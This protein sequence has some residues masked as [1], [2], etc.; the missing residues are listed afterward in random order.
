MSN[1]SPR[2]VRKLIDKFFSIQ[3]CRDN[4]VVPLH[5]ENSLP[6]IR[7]TIKIAIANFS[8]L[9]T[10]ASPIKERL[11]Q[12]GY[13]CE[14]VERSQEEI[15]KILDL[16]SEE[17]FLTGDK[18]SQFDEDAVLEAIKETS[19][20]NSDTFDFEFDDE[21]EL[22]EDMT[23][24]LAVE[25]CESKIQNAA[26]TILINARQRNVSDIH[27]EP[28]ENSYLVRVRKDGVMH[29]FMSLPRKAGIQLVACLKNMAYMDIAERRVSQDGKI[30]RKFE[31]NKIEFR[32]STVPNT[33]G[34][35]MVLRILNSDASTLNLDF[36]I[37]IESVRENFRKI[38]S[39]NNGII[40]VSGP[41]G[42]GKSTTLAATLIELNNGDTNIVTAEDPVEYKLGGGISQSQVNRAKGQT[43]AMLLR[44]FL[45]QDPDVILIGETRDPETAESAMD[46]AETGHLVFTTLHANSS[47]SSLTRLIDM[48]V[49]KYKLNA[50]VRGVLAQRL[51][52]K[53]C[54]GCGT[55]RGVSE[56]ESVRYGIDEGTPV[57][58]ANALSAE[59]K[60]K[61]KRESSLCP[62]CFGI[63][64]QGRIGVYELLEVNRDIQIAIAE[65]KS[66]E[67]IEN[68]AVNKNNMLT[69]RKY[70]LELIKEGL[71]TFSELERVI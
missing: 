21:G 22:E 60:S 3:W 57:M 31:G 19:D 17:R 33:N 44:T 49:P 67:E 39:S 40:I 35:K 45:R 52:R 66:I 50:S 63:G 34:E 56:S 16:A 61:R 64:Y 41:T 27:I 62:K 38:M 10:I 13:T 43:F 12:S 48:E 59:E 24:D 11:N 54:T 71:T 32:C 5:E 69:L 1:F 70:G 2:D 7:A 30:I 42:S 47:T 23:L 65:K 37:H 25:M 29:N 9:G 15:Q 51:I 58:Y 36:L 28:M 14:F 68:I 20:N 53:V 26:G 8:Y 6:M 46:A 4:L 18:I 55:Q